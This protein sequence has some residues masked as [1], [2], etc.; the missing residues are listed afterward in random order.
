VDKCPPE[1]VAGI[2]GDEGGGITREDQIR[3][4]H[5]PHN[6]PSDLCPPCKKPSRDSDSWFT[7]G[8]VYFL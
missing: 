4:E 7:A 3:I 6:D 2:G 8:I 5:K 1:L